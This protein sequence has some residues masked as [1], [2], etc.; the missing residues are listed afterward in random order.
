M[1]A[2]AEVTWEAPAGKI[3]HTSATLEDTSRSGA[4]IRLKAPVQ[5]G[6]K[7][8]VNGTENSFLRSREIAAE[9]GASFCWEFDVNRMRVP[10]LP[11]ENPK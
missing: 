2:V 5:V 8:T 7:I 10:W 9:K 3:N 1:W 6:S 11:S 4:C